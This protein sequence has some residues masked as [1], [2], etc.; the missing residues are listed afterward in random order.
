[1]VHEAGSSGLVA[2]PKATGSRREQ[3]ADIRRKQLIAEWRFEGF[4]SHTIKTQQTSLTCKPE[5][6]VIGLCQGVDIVK[7][8]FFE[9]PGFVT[10]QAR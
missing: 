9:T 7:R 5:E 3:D 8:A 1:V 2:D 6:T 10:L 4:E